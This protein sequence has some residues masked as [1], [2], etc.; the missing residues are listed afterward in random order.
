[1]LKIEKRGKRKKKEKQQQTTIV[2]NTVWASASIISASM[3]NLSDEWPRN[4]QI[5]IPNREQ[6]LMSKY[7]NP[8]KNTR[9]PCKYTLFN[10]F[11]QTIICASCIPNRQR[12]ANATNA[13]CFK[14]KFIG[15]CVCVC[16]LSVYKCRYAILCGICV[17][18]IV[19]VA[20]EIRKTDHHHDQKS[21]FFEIWIRFREGTVQTS[22]KNTVW[23]SRDSNT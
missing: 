11:L 10:F 1:M 14:R 18:L 5:Y 13:Y 19:F 17:T 21:K 12:E 7:W 9:A 6:L 20:I 8:W 4:R 16:F 2:R 3:Y 23:R 15:L 22:N